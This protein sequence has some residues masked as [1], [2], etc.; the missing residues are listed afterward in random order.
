MAGLSKPSHHIHSQRFDAVIGR[1]PW[2]NKLI[3]HIR[4]LN[5]NIFRRSNL[6]K[7]H[8][9]LFQLIRRIGEILGCFVFLKGRKEKEKKECGI[10]QFKISLNHCAK[11]IHSKNEDLS[12]RVK[13]CQQNSLGF[14][15][16]F[17]LF[18]V[19]IDFF[20]SKY[21]TFNIFNFVKKIWWPMLKGAFDGD[22]NNSTSKPMNKRILLNIFVICT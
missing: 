10:F 21:F 7:M 9:G 18:F 3:T 20:I 16:F 8:Y 13:V 11:N 5:R 1:I 2:Y 6:C 12:L 22:E 17:V 19:I 15:N 14:D 4:L